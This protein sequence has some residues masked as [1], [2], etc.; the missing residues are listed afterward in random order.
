LRGDSPNLIFFEAGEALTK[1]CQTF[2]ATLHRFRR[3]VPVGVQTVALPNGFFQ[4]V[5]VV[6]LAI[7]KAANFQSKAVGPQVHS[8]KSRSILHKLLVVSP[9]EH[10]IQ[11]SDIT[12]NGKEVASGPCGDKAVPNG[13]RVS[14]F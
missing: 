1:T 6:N 3:E 9:D 5:G 12:Y 4:V 7:I 13:V 11:L 2:P 10:S 8:R 14:Q